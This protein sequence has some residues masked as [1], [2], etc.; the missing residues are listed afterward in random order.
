MIKVHGFEPSSPAEVRRWLKAVA[1]LDRL[2][3]TGEEYERRASAYQRAHPT[4]AFT[5][6]AV[7]GRWGELGA[8][9]QLD[10]SDLGVNEGKVLRFAISAASKFDPE[11]FE[12]LLEEHY[13]TA[14]A[15]LL[16]QAR[17]IYQEARLAA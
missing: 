6:K 10:R 4:W 5:P 11:T 7:L 8:I 17:T 2:G 14:P 9:K 16:D 13:G 12:G 15:E 1:T 3:A